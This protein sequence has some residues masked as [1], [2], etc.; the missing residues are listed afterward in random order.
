MAA[1]FSRVIG[2]GEKILNREFLGKNE[3]LEYENTTR[4]SNQILTTMVLLQILSS[5]FSTAD[6]LENYIPEGYFDHF[7]VLSIVHS[8]HIVWDRL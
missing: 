2:W 7:V 6:Y 3:T 5:S 8:M 4:I 1:F